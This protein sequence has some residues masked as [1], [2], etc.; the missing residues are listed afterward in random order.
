[1]NE[2]EQKKDS[3][4]KKSILGFFIGLAVIV[5]GISGSTIAI[6]F[7]LYN[8]ILHAL[9]NFIKEFKISIL[10]LAPILLGGIIGVVAGF[11][12]IQKLIDLIPFAI[13]SLFG[14]LMLGA[15]PSLR[16]EVKDIRLEKKHI[17]LLI[18][19]FVIPL[20]MSGASL[21]LSE[22]TDIPESRLTT[23]F[24]SMC[25][26]LILGILVAA[27]Q[28]IPGCSATATLMALG[29]FIPLM[30]S[31]HFSYIQEN[32]MVLLI[33]FMLMLGFILGCAAVSKIF[34]FLI[35][36]FKGIMYFIFIGLSLG[37]ILCLFLNS[38][39]IQIYRGWVS[40]GSFPYLD[41]FLGVGLFVCGA[42]IAYQLVV[43]MRKKNKAGL[44]D[45]NS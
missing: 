40:S 28:F 44:Q 37:S 16:D 21:L 42:L 20:L 41:I 10:F 6:I 36:K 8:K 24:P 31:F 23:D 43:Y 4:I 27:T 34:N 5:P 13:I 32:P 25:I 11:F 30:N 3:F 33:Y 14:G 7:K 22:S 12:T 17:F 9:A 29:Y 1:M 26:Y 39:M 15:I 18:L 38:D 19:G 2:K 45:N 35:E